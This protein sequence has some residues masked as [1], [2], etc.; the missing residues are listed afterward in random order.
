MKVF[1]RAKL[2]DEEGWETFIVIAWACWSTR[3]KR[4]FG[5]LDHNPS[6]LVEKSLDMVI[7]F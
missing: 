5:T 1:E 2:E 3:N 4:L 7:E 6:T